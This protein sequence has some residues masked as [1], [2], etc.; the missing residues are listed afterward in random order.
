MRDRLTFLL[1]GGAL[2]L[3]GYFMG[4]MHAPNT[5]EAQTT[6]LSSDTRYFRYGDALITTSADGRTLHF[7][8]TNER[9]KELERKPILVASVTADAGK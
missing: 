2:V 8:S 4:Q 7:W 9:N 5:A 3:A 1:L 6:V